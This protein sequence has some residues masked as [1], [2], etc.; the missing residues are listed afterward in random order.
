MLFGKGSTG[1]I[2]N[3]VNKQPFLITQHELN[4]TLGTGKEDRLTGEFNDKTGEESAL[5]INSMVQEADNY[6]ATSSKRGIAPTYRFD[7]NSQ[8]TTR[9]RHGRYERDLW[10][11][12]I[13]FGQTKGAATT[14]NNLS[15]S[16]PIT[17]SPKGRIG[18]SDTTQFQND[19]T[20]S[21]SALGKKHDLIAGVDYYQ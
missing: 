14:I 18:I 20:G 5:R 4:Y 9:L 11:S 12:A 3:Q 16:T 17:R 19:Y 15:P 2:V 10:A 1:G 7:Q 8:I 13:R 21:F 6:G